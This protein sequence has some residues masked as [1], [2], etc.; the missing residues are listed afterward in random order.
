[1]C[2]SMYVSVFSVG[3][4]VFVYVCVR[5]HMYECAQ[6]RM[7]VCMHISA[8]PSL[9]PYWEQIQTSNRK[10]AV[11]NGVTEDWESGFMGQK[12]RAPA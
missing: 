12:P 7:C 1:M 4:C 10:P 5:A 3:M 2:L 9:G 8:N 6:V 11:K